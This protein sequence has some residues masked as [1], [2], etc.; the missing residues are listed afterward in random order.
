M[1]SKMA[2]HNFLFISEAMGTDLCKLHQKMFPNGRMI[3]GGTSMGAAASL[4]AA[5]EAKSLW[6]H[7]IFLSFRKLK[8]CVGQAPEKI[9]ALILATPPTAWETRDPTC[10]GMNH[11]MNI[12]EL[13]TLL[14]PPF[15]VSLFEV[16]S[17]CLCIRKVWNLPRSMA[18]KWPNQLL[19]RRQEQEKNRNNGIL[20]VSCSKHWQV[21]SRKVVISVEASRCPC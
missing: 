20:V 4:Y 3:L 18:L 5:L 9:G 19:R 8:S 21:T 15:F 6:H 12:N 16:E 13:Y 7:S 2:W 14:F 11:E 17:L 10:N 1:V